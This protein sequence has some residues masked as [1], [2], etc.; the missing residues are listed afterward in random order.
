MIM[1]NYVHKQIQLR[2]SYVATVVWK[3][4]TVEYFGVKFVRGKIVSSLGVS[5][6]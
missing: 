5:N 2:C 1:I 6:K 4:F 3:K